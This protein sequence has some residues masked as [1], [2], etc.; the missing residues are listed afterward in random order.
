M[1]RLGRSLMGRMENEGSPDFRIVD[2]YVVGH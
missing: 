1:R 2:A